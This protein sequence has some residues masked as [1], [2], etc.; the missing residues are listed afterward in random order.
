MAD[1]GSTWVRAGESARLIRQRCGFDDAAPLDAGLILGSGLGDLAEEIEDAT[2]VPYEDIPHFPR[3]TVEGHAGRLVIGRLAG[4]TVL[5]MQGRFHYY[6]GYDMAEVT[7]G[8]RVT[9]RLGVPVL[10]VTNAAGGLNPD[11][12]PGDLMLITDHLNLMP[13]N[14][15][16][17]H[18]DERFGPRFPSPVGVYDRTL[19]EAAHG[20]AARAE[21]SCRE[22]VYAALPGPNYETEAEVAWLRTTGADAVGMSTVPEV[23]VAAHGGQKV[24]AVSTITNVLGRRPGQVV[25]HDEVLDVAARVRE[26]MGSLV[27]GFLGEAPLGVS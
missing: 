13:Q 24:L 7:F 18:N 25:T 20:A 10:V 12:E 26:R 2:V 27:K 11:F 19:L 22:G 21:F 23:L 5:A 14:P 1:T 3:P 17:G 4:R 9:Q 16:R 15:L 6:E 8:V